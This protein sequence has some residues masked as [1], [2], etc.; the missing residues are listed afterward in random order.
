MRDGV[1]SVQMHTLSK[2]DERGYPVYIDM[3]L[4][5][6]MTYML[7]LSSETLDTQPYL[8]SY[9]L[10]VPQLFSDPTP[11]FLY[12][13]PCRLLL[14]SS[15]H[16]YGAPIQ[17][18]QQTSQAAVHGEETV[19]P[20]PRG[21]GGYLVGPPTVGRR[22]SPSHGVAQTVG[23]PVR[24]GGCRSARGGPDMDVGGSYQDGR[25]GLRAMAKRCL[26]NALGQAVGHH[27]AL[28]QLEP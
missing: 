18:D 25:D 24:G 26:W 20:R 10:L 7:T 16:Q 17:E 23:Y 2:L 5:C 13:R 27:L 15:L 21:S 22:A 4:D 11:I 19:T 28:R 8:L 3:Q 1:Q 9:C 6:S 14:T 12:L